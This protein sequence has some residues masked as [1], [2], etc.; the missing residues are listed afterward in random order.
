MS[1]NVFVCMF[2]AFGPNFVPKALFFA[3]VVHFWGR[4][5]KSNIGLLAYLKSLSYLN[6][7]III[8]WSA[9]MS[10]ISPDIITAVWYKKPLT[11]KSK[12]AA[13]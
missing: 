4:S 1:H 12:A 7:V 5:W 2:F 9:Q 3:L 11:V 6:R 13:I 10:S 8:V